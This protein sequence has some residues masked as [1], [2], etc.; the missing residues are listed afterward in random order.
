[1]RVPAKV[2]KVLFVNKPEPTT[3]AFKFENG[4]N[5]PGTTF[6]DCSTTVKMVEQE[7]R[8]H[9]FGFLGETE[10]ARV[11]AGQAVWDVECEGYGKACKLCGPAT[12]F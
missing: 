11:K 6:V 8:L 1:M 4:P 5:N 7:T 2:Y 9:F 10:Q 3:L 12:S